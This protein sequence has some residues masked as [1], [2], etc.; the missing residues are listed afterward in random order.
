M[1]ILV[2]NAGSSSLKF[3]FFDLSIKETHIF[4]GEFKNSKDGKILLEVH[5]TPIKETSTYPQTYNTIENALLDI[6][7]ILRKFGYPTFDAIGHRVVHGGINSPGTSLINEHLL[8]TIESSIPLAPLHN[9]AS[10]SIIRSSLA[11]WSTIPQFAVFDTTFHNTIPE[12]ANSYAIPSEWRNMGIKRYGFHGIS[13]KFVASSILDRFKNFSENSKII[14]CHLGN[15]GS[16]CAIRNG[17]SIDTSMGMTPLEGIVMGTRSGD[18]DP[19]IFSYLQRTLGLNSAE[20]EQKLNSESGLKAL[21]GTNDML[22]IEERFQ[23][24]CNQAAL[25]IDIYVYHV[26]KY[27]GAYIAS[28][29]GIDVL[30]FTGGIG[31]NSAHVRNLICRNFNFLG[32]F[33]DEKINSAL[34]FYDSNLE[35]IQ[36]TKSAVKIIVLKTCEEYMI[37]KEILEIH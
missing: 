11:T 6:S 37:A 35:Q 30:S 5:S 9:P 1:R 21:T 28:L 14:S 24:G 16:L 33:I 2:F 31:E 25:A 13:H 3:A 34:H 4:K 23:A 26:Q 20:V 29:G 36:S 7:S 22:T 32:L 8:S 17:I 18:I 19:G 12:H 15:G 10:L 27:I